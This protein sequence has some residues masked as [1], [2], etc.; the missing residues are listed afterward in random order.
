MPVRAQPAKVATPPEA[1]SGLVVQPSAPDEGL[2][3]M[4]ADE[5][6]TTL[7]PE[8]S[9][10]TTGWALKATPLVELP[11]DV[12]KTSWVADPTLMVM[13]PVV[14]V[15]SPV[16]VAESWVGIGG[17]GDGTAG[18]GGTPEVVVNGLVVQAACPS[19]SSPPG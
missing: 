14:A 13:F 6:V 10:V 8:S 1:L 15:V 17:A 11:G 12:V 3:K 9:T 2:S 5:P 4:D 16:A 7:P 19:Q 18:E